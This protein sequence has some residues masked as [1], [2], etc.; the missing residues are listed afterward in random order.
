MKATQETEN[1]AIEHGNYELIKGEFTP[2]EAIEI[3]SHLISTKINFHNL[4]NFS[5]QVRFDIKDEASLGRIRELEISRELVKQLANMA[6]ANGKSLRVK[7]NI[8]IELF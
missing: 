8:I 4:Q 2:D 5:K 3:I 7:S 6:K 1:K